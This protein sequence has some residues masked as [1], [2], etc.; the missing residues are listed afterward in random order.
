MGK[1]QDVSL[2]QGSTTNETFPLPKH[3]A[4]CSAWNSIP[5]PS[6]GSWLNMAEIE[7][8]MLER[9]ALSR[10]LGDEAALRRQVE[11]VECERNEQRRSITWQFTSHDARRKLEQLYPVKAPRSVP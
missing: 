8:A 7:I 3:V 2:E 6:T 1:G 4:S 9:N 10:R 11:A 5:P